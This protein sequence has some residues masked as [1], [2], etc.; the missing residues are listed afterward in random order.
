MCIVHRDRSPLRVKQ[1][2]GDI[3][4]LG[5]AR[6]NKEHKPRANQ[7][8]SLLEV[9]RQLHTSDL[10]RTYKLSHIRRWLGGGGKIKS[11]SH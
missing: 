3:L 2:A 1:G 4:A 10:A 11:G 6:L 8:K 5:S 7:T 9:A